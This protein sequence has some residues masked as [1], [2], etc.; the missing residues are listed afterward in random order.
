[1]TKAEIVAAIVHSGRGGMLGNYDF[2]RANGRHFV[3]IWR[4]GEEF[5]V[6]QDREGLW[7]VQPIGLRSA[8]C[9]ADLIVAA[10]WALSE[11]EGR[12]P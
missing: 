2:D 3:R 4:T 1:M 8:W 6:W 12:K 9:N 11:I 10:Q 7:N 5:H